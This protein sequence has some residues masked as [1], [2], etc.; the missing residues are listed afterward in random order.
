MSKDLAR[1]LTMLFGKYYDSHRKE[2]VMDISSFECKLLEENF[3][4]G[5][6]EQIEKYIGEKMKNVEY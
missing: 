4:K 1:F 3:I 2:N 5:N 6:F